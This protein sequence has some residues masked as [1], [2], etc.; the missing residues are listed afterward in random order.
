M[1]FWNLKVTTKQFNPLILSSKELGIKLIQYAFLLNNTL[2]SKNYEKYLP[3]SL[4]KEL[5]IFKGMQAFNW[6][7]IHTAFNITTQID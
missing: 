5:G 1:D 3:T 4:L 7:D 2:K 6:N